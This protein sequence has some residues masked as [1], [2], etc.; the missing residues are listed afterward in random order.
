MN[1]PTILAAIERADLTCAEYRLARRLLDRC[2]NQ[3]TVH[4]S[5]EEACEVCGVVSWPGAK[6]LLNK[7][8]AC[9]LIRVHTNNYAYI[10]FWSVPNRIH[11]APN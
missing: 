11:S 7:L 10:A 2:S 5:S 6:K 8:K 9:G 1:Y 4:L 3:W